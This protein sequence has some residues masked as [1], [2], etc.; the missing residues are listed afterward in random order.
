MC[1]LNVCFVS[2]VRPRTFGCV[3]I[4]SAVLYI[5]VI[6]LIKCDSSTATVYQHYYAKTGELTR[7]TCTSWM[8]FNPNVYGGYEIY[9]GLIRYPLRICTE[10]QTIYQ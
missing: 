5:T 2:K 9:S 4:G 8:Y 7:M 3:A 1:V 10:E 6:I